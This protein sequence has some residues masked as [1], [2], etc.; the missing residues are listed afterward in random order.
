M[1][2]AVPAVLS[3]K[4]GEQRAIALSEANVI[5]SLVATGGPLLVG[6]FASSLGDWRYVL[7]LAAASPIFLY[8]GFGRGLKSAFRG[9]RPVYK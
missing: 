9:V 6:L 4:H 3:E 8:L 1:R 2:I 5:A 7:G